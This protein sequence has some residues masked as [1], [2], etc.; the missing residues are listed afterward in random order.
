MPA[1]VNA[2]R[3]SDNLWDSEGKKFESITVA[4]GN[5]IVD[6]ILQSYFRHESIQSSAG[7]V[8]SFTKGSVGL[9][10]RLWHIMG[11]GLKPH[12]IE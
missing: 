10:T 1:T 11:K 12:N 3:L 6:I 2:T 5:V 7:L 9:E 8:Q 4:Q